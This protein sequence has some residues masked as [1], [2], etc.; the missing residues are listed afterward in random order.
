MERNETSA[1]V[2][3]NDIENQILTFDDLHRVKT[4]L[5][6]QHYDAFLVY[7]DED[8]DFAQEIIENLEQKQNLK[9]TKLKF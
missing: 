1:D 3:D 7:A 4:G 5:S 6:T 2:V 8:A 9:V